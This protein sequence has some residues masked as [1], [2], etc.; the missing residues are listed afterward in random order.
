MP[1]A[2]AA[3]VHAFA[4]DALADHDAVGLTRLLASG[5]VS[6]AELVD[7]AIARTQALDPRLAA[8]AV[9]RYDRARA[10]GRSPAGGFFS[11]IPTFVK[12]NSDLEGLA[13]QQGTRAYAGRPRTQHGDFARMLTALGVVPLGKT[14]L[15]EFGFSASA[16][17]VDEPPV[18]NPW[19]PEHTSGASSAG[20]AALVAAGAVPMAH[21]NDGGGSIRIPAA[22]CGLV[23]LKPTRDRV[24]SDALTRQMPVRI[25]ADGVV[26]RSV[27]DSAA[28]LREAEKV[29]RTLSLPPVGDITRAGRRR[30]RI[31]LVSESIGGRTVDAETAAALTR[32]AGELEEAG[33]HVEPVA[34]PVPESFADDFLLYWA[35]L[36]L[37]L[38]RT[39]R[40][41]LDRSFDRRRTDNL[42][43]GLA[44]HALRNAWRLPGAMRRLRGT[45]RISET[46]FA[47]HDVVLSPTVGHLTPRLGHLHPGQEYDVIIERL[48]DWVCFTPWQNAT[49]EPAISL[50]AGL[51][52]QGLPIGVMLAAPQGRDARLLELAYEVEE[53]LPFPV[54]SG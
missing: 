43:Q 3:R 2:A 52:A 10:E 40:F 39:G 45:T 14:R 24:V 27:R 16:E 53:R 7:A 21:A 13:T 5:R 6:A 54:I 26:T 31:A 32:V 1:D 19:S 38:T 35:T 50:P 22:C 46:L 42:T 20:S 37:H 12:D 33:H 34:P 11:G 30:L 25:V 48:L 29:Y 47:D 9:E 8:V 51:S 44:R 49:G 23:G 28:F 41:T 36:A 17:F 15:S 18:R 4:D